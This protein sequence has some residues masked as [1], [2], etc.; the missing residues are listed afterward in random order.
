[1][2]YVK[3]LAL[4]LVVIVGVV[5]VLMIQGKPRSEPFDPKIVGGT[6]ADPDRYPYFAKLMFSGTYQGVTYPSTR[7]CGGALIAPDKIVTAAHC[8]NPKLLKYVHVVIGGNEIRRVREVQISQDSDLAML[9]LASPSTKQ[10]IKLRTQAL[11]NL[12]RVKALGTGAKNPD[13][14][15]PGGNS[16]AFESLDMMYVDNKT[17]ASYLRQ[18][19]AIN[20]RVRLG[21]Q[22]VLAN[23]S[24]NLFAVGP[25]G[26]AVCGGDS[27][28]PLIVDAGRLGPS[29]DELVGVFSF[30]I[31]S[32]AAM[33]K[34]WACDP[35]MKR[36]YVAY[37]QPTMSI[38]VPVE[39]GPKK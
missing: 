8:I 29:Q 28:G 31:L 14:T 23:S 36:S 18:E 38:R 35:S 21:W 11:P 1:M 22:T 24:Q 32:T 37:T 15:A 4:W 9:T 2:S 7:F 25:P 20:E 13:A 5:C 17:A 3:K 33:S 6:T 30:A 10:P 19:T 16:D 34:N 39:A 27:G 26:K 12:S